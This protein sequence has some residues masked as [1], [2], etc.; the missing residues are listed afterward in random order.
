LQERQIKAAELR[1]FGQA[2]IGVLTGMDAAFVVRPK[3]AEAL[4]LEPDLV[5]P[6]AYRGADV[7]RY[8][9]SSPRALVIYPYIEGPGGSPQ[10][11]P[12]TVMAVKYPNVHRHLSSFREQLVGRMDSRKLYASGPDWYRH[13]RAGSFRYIRPPKFLIKGIDTRASVGL[14]H[15]NTCFNGANSPGIILDNTGDHSPL[16]IL[17]LLN[18]RLLSYYL[19]TVCPAKLGGYTRFNA[20]NIN[21]TPIRVIAFTHAEDRARHDRIVAL[22][23]RML[24]LH[25]QQAAAKTGHDK[26][27]IGRQIEA[28]ERQIDRLVYELYGLTEEE[29][30]IVEGTASER[31]ND[32]TEESQ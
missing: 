23:E 21:N 2:Y 6:Y 4:E 31:T 16:Y 26:T 7:A 25:K 8:E 19:R 29:I 32:S 22:V 27:L 17:G 24:A 18:S 14:L 20:N 9:E 15:R 5:F 10:L 11:I 13:L 30:G 3:E 12:E 1:K 28:T